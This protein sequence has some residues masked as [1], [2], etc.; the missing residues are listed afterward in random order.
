MTFSGGTEITKVFFSREKS[1]QQETL[2]KISSIYCL[3]EWNEIKMSF[4]IFLSYG[5]VRDCVRLMGKGEKIISL[6][7]NQVT[8]SQGI[9]VCE[10]L[11]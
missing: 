10:T 8:E 11:L 3:W 4:V 6:T 5:F 2:V 9:C 7:H 1:E